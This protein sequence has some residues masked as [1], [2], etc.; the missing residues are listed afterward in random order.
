MDKLKYKFDSLEQS[1][2][3][4]D[5]ALSLLNDMSDLTYEEDYIGKIDITTQQLEL[6]QSKTNLLVDEFKKLQNEEY[7]S[8]D[9][10]SELASRMKSVADSINENQKQIIE[11]G[12]NVSSYYMSALT[13]IS[14]LS[15]D[16]ISRATSLIDRNIKTLSEGGLTGLQFN[17]IPTMPQSAIERQR[18]ENATLLNDMSSYYD[19]VAEMQ[20]TALDLQFQEQMADNARKKEE[21]LK[22]LNEQKQALNDYFVDVENKQKT[23]DNTTTQE[24]STDLTNKT[25]QVQTFTDAVKD[26][27]SELL[28]WLQNN[29]IKPK[30]DTS[31]I[32][33]IGAVAGVGAGGSAIHG[34]TIAESSKA[35]I[36][37]P[38][39]WGGTDLEKGVDC[40]GF[41]QG[42]YK[43]NGIDI[44]RTANEQY[45]SEKGQNIV[46][47]TNLQAGDLIFFD[48][49]GKG[50][51]THVGMYL[52]NGKMI[53][54]PTT[55]Q[56][57]KEEVDIFNNRYWSNHFLGGKRFYATGTKDYGIAGENYRKEY[58]IDK[59]TG[60]WH[61]INEPTLFDTKEF[62]IV[63]EKVSEKIDKPICTF[64]TGTPISDISVLQMVKKACEET[65]VPANI[66]LSV[67]DQESGNK[68]IGK[69]P[70][71]KGYSY[72]YMQL[73]DH[74]A[75]TTVPQNSR[76]AAMN[77]PETNILWGA[78]YL[79]QM[80]DSVGGNWADA[81]SAYNQGLGNFKKYGRN[82]YG[83]NVYNRANSSAFVEA[84][85][86]LG[87][88]SSS[89][90]TISSTAPASHLIQV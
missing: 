29:P 47:T 89:V 43:Q 90:A 12:K 59:K 5:N 86:Q 74:G 38:Y 17:I 76:L 68:W 54:A 9:S 42:V 41:V 66:L 56:T 26:T 10:A 24:M 72:G 18:N 80:Y 31:D 71:G 49:E 83:N 22:T 73:Y 88:I 14:S 20:K 81:A 69:N 8:A 77:D 15:K 62:D 11:Y 23:H 85:Q 25:I 61:E 13:S 34:A 48:F 1:I 44:P 63:G 60:E 50:K 2:T 45:I 79:K 52:G 75:L 30:V 33:D 40:S 21:L 87:S 36:G 53:H 57:V 3:K 55:G 7:N 84:A 39:V 19:S 70:D 4:V 37:T 46:S 27:V 51:A 28:N 32:P 78:K 65:G 16:S 6:T 58:A 64:A 82:A 67:I 35:Y